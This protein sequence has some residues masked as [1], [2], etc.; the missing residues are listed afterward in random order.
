[1]D[2]SITEFCQRLRQAFWNGHSINDYSRKLWTV[3]NFS[4]LHQ[5]LN[6][7]FKD[8]EGSFLDKISAQISE[9]KNT[10]SDLSDEDQEALLPLAFELLSVYYVFPLNIS[11]RTK[12]NN[13][14]DLLAIN[15]GIA[16]KINLSIDNFPISKAA[17]KA[18]G[19]GSGGM[20]YNTNKQ[21]EFFYL[22]DVC[23]TYYEKQSS[24]RKALDYTSEDKISFQNFLD[25]VAG[26]RRP[27]LRH[28]LLH[29]LFPEYYTPI[30]SSSQKQ[31]IVRV[32][33]GFYDDVQLQDEWKGKNVKPTDPVDQIIRVV[34]NNLKKQRGKTTDFYDPELAQFWDA[35]SSEIFEDLDVELLDYKKQVVLYGPP[36][37]SKTYTA[38]Q[39]AKEIIRYRMAKNLGVDIFREDGQRKLRRA[40][41]NNIHRLQLHPAYSY[42]DFIQGLHFEEGDTRIKPGYLLNL[43]EKMEQDIPHVLILD[44]INRVDLSR[45][46][47]ECFSAL[48][49]RGEAI[50][51]LGF[52]GNNSNKLIIP[53][54][55]YIIG[56]MNLID[57]S[58]EQLD[59]ALRRRFLWVEAGYNPDALL[60]MSYT[61]WCA[62]S[63]RDKSISWGRVE[64][65]F[66][67]LVISAN[68]INQA[69]RDEPELGR[70]FELGHVFFAETV[71]F[72][73]QFLQEK[74]RSQTFLFAKNG[75]WRDPIEK[76]W[77]LS[78][79]PLLREYLS[80][81]DG[82]SQGRIL[83]KLKDAFR[84]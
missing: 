32:F 3:E 34:A 59:F 14:K 69:I 29:L 24:I 77:R 19:I 71:S 81:L 5:A 80:G 15:I 50:D 65:D 13:L 75:S 47:G 73:H 11:P 61:K 7:N 51:L 43:L 84:P 36:G 8:G 62:L 21:T 40:L 23:K 35:A 55:L 78:L 37:T 66:E 42:E 9:A 45:L 79:S 56:T 33:A 41:E 46:F 2:E 52:S 83:K 28:M 26:D 6:D 48:E 60:Q 30:S 72:L 57:H 68:K 25:D 76:L 44:E 18:R 70:D 38:K 58:I 12:E 27:Q 39:L 17:I 67:M 1:M 16:K 31:R 4:N 64:P 49:N 74:P 63:W 53:D 54:N 82:E 22:V 10:I 20:G